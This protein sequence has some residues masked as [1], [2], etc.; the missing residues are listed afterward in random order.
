MGTK[1]LKN[2]EAARIIGISPSTLPVWR[3]KGIG[4]KFIQPNG[5]GTAVYYTVADINAWIEAAEK[6]TTADAADVSALRTQVQML[7][8]QLNALLK[9]I[10][11]DLVPTQ[12]TKKE[13][14]PLTRKERAMRALGI[15]LGRLNVMIAKGILPSPDLSPEDFDNAVKVAAELWAAERA[16]AV[17][18]ELTKLAEKLS[19][20]LEGGYVQIT[21]AS[22]SWSACAYRR[23]GNLYVVGPTE[24]YALRE[25]AVAAQKTKEGK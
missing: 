15:T 16:S 19:S 20:E 8:E 5:T 10:C 17:S 6:Q 3:S 21:Y 2:A 4:P 23:R 14:P 13:P 7:H 22:G 12:E 1:F 25:L 24:A 9:G 11:P 18:M